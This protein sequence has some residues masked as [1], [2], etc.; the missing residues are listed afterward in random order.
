MDLTENDIMGMAMGFQKSRVLLTAFELGVFS[1]VG[2]DRKSPEEIAGE[3]TV[4]ARA[5]DRLMNAL[6]AMGLLGKKDG[7]FFNTPTS[8]RYLTKQSPEYIAGLMHGANLWNTWSTLTEAV[9]NGKSVYTDASIDQRDPEWLKAFIS[10]MH[11]RGKKAAPAL[12]SMLDLSGV[13]S[14]LDVGGG[15]GVYAMAMVKANANIRATV[16][17]LP[18]VVSLTRRYIESEGLYGKVATLE[19]DYHVDS[20]GSGYDLILL[21]SI[22]HSHSSARNIKLLEK[23]VQALHPNGQVVV[24]EFIVDEDRV[25]PEN[26]A[27]FALNMLVGTDGGDTYTESEVRGWM[28]WVGLTA[29]SRTDTPFGTTLMIGRKGS[30]D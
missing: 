25:H 24:Q 26:A 23:C 14:V 18:N 29:I 16:F 9:R 21:S 17:D 2:D 8:K 27:F 5:V 11:F 22:L 15:S 3:L 13:S 1:V 20:L 10:A 19:G 4:N 6:C 12:V 7:L 28:T 30:S